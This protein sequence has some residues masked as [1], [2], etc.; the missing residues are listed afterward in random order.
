MGGTTRLVMTLIAA[1]TVQAGQTKRQ[2]VTVYVQNDANVS[3]DVR[4]R[5][6]QLASSMFAAIDVRIEWHN[7]Q[8]SAAFSQQAIAINLVRNTPKTERPGALA[9]AMPN[10]GVHIVV[11]WDGIEITLIPTEVLAHV[12]VHEIT[13]I[14]EGVNR[15]SEIGIMRSH[16]TDEDRKVMQMHPLSFAPVDVDLIHRG[17]AARSGSQ[18]GPKTSLR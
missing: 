14:L 16:W 17:L 13:H 4:D 10:E 1:V 2:H 3:Q 9:F 8:P 7:G 15:R 11:F 18:A 6:K 5:A 12:M